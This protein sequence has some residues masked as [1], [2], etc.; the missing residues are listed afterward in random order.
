M[1][2]GIPSPRQK[3]TGAALTPEAETTGLSA[4]RLDLLALVLGLT[5]LTLG[6]LAGGLFIFL[7][8]RNQGEANVLA[9]TTVGASMAALGMGVGGVLAWAGYQGLRKGPSRPFRPGL[10]W[11]WVCL[12][13]LAVALPLGQLATSLE[14]G[15]P[16]A[17]PLFH[18]LGVASPAVAILVLIGWG[19]QGGAE[20]AQD[21][22]RPTQRQVIA[23][24][25][26]GAFGAT[27]ISFALEAIMAVIGL[28]LI[29]MVLA[30]TPGGAA[31]LAE[32]QAILRDPARWQDL[33]T[34]ARWVLKPGI[35]LAVGVML[36]VIAPMIEEGAKSLGVPLLALATH[37]RPGS[38][39]GW[40]WGVAVGVGFAIAEGLFN[41]AANLS[42]WAGIALLRIG[43]TA[44]HAVTAGVTGLGWARTLTSRRLGGVLAGYLTSVTLHGLWNGLTVLMVISSLWAV[45]QSTNPAGVAMAG[46][47]VLVGLA[48]LAFLTTLIIGVAVYVTLRMR[49]E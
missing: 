7:S 41:G 44:M 24:L 33:D 29:G 22:T 38:V 13:G 23:Q 26:L 48:G 10:R 46:L 36:V 3:P 35:L 32:L 45:I 15:A 4:R 9:V 27:A 37:R 21:D 30:L 2:T 11:L 40:M 14:P 42:F 8:L 19:V 25:T 6:P 43:A 34:L 1:D 17:F 47:G 18:V 31:Q 20:S 49:G 28:F 39:Q 16:V 12:V 5:A